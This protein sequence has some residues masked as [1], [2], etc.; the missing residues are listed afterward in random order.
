[1]RKV[2][3]ALT[4][5]SWFKE[6]LKD[7]VTLN[8]A[9]GKYDKDANPKVTA[10]LVNEFKSKIMDRNFSVSEYNCFIRASKFIVEYQLK[11]RE[12]INWNSCLSEKMNH[13]AFAKRFM[14]AI[15]D[16]AIDVKMIEPS[17][18]CS[19]RTQ[20]SRLPKYLKKI[21]LLEADVIKST[22]TVAKAQP[23]SYKYNPGYQAG[24]IE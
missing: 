19:V 9:F 11:N 16:D 15:M 22:T 8:A 14:K 4:F 6:C 5:D 18:M 21:G 23:K 13:S 24:E 17:W 20:E 10:T 2:R 3:D 1:M 12:K 7:E